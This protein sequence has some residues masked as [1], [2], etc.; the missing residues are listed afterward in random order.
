MKP[1]SIPYLRVFLLGALLL[2]GAAL[3]ASWNLPILEMH[4][5]R[6][7]QTAISSYWMARSGGGLAYPTP[8]LGYPWSIPFEFPLFQAVAMA[9]WKLLPVTL[10]QAGR[11]VS[12]L[13]AIASLWPLRRCLR[14]LGATDVLAD[15]SSVF[16]LLSPLYL[17]WSRAFLIESTAL[18]FSLG[19]LALVAISRRR[20]DAAVLSAMFA[21]ALLAALVKITTFFGFALAAAAV[22]LLEH[23]RHRRDW[24]PHEIASRYA[25]AAVSVLAAIL[26][27]KAWLYFGDLQKAKTVWG[28]ALGS[29]NLDLW[30]FGTWEQ[31]TGPE[32][33]RAVVFG[34]AAQDLLGF[35][36]LLP[37]L[38][39][40]AL[41]VRGNRALAWSALWLYLAPF[42]VFTNVHFVHNYYQYANGIFLLVLAGC[43]VEAIALR[44]G[45][46]AGLTAVL[47][48]CVLML[49]GFRREFLGRLLWQGPDV[50]RPMALADHARRH[51]SPDEVL[52]GFGLDWSA[53]VP[54]YAQRR[55][56]LVPDWIQPVQ[57]QAMQEDPRRI[58]GRLSLGLVIVC[59]NQLDAQPNTRADYRKLLATVTAGRTRTDFSGCAFYR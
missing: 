34:R 11:L 25:P 40:P 8:I 19:F 16:F 30:N 4:G 47:L 38:A 57:I 55:A 17:C 2:S 23:W 13:F 9:V 59:P 52:L 32:L 18:F 26:I 10:D 15:A 29:H 36:W 35:A 12:W 53:E 14:E 41:F 54:Y 21:C 56:M 6:Q 42:L 39:L 48:V 49:I 3:V 46:W 27:L 22:L 44:A 5:F 51:T 24:G 45:R 31:R 43:G 37:A 7:T 1:T 58:S 33:W 20:R 28:A 50:T